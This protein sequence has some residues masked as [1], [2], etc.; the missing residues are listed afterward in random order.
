MTHAAGRR[1]TFLPVRWLISPSSDIMWLLGSVLVAYA[2]F[3]AFMSGWLSFVQIGLIWVFLFHGPHFWGTLSRTYVDREQ[4]RKRRKLFLTALWWFA[5]GPVIVGL[6]LLIE[7]ATPAESVNPGGR[8]DLIR[9][10]FFL[11]AVWA[12]HHV[13]KQRQRR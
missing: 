3:F 11:A 9:L 7:Y 8:N 10:F 5:V 13:V 12:F 6:G 1:S 2:M 4:F